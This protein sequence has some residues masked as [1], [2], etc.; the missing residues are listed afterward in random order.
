MSAIDHI[1]MIIPKNIQ[2]ALH[3]LVDEGKVW[4]KCPKCMIPLSI[5]EYKKLKCGVCG[6]ISLKGENSITF[7]PKTDMC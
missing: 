3:R 5:Q 2:I 6:K 7:H 1:D 4:A